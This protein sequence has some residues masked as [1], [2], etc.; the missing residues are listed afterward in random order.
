MFTLVAFEPGRE[1]T[2]ATSPSRW[3]GAYAL[4]YRVVAV[5]AR[6]SRLTV[7]L[8]MAYPPVLR[9]VLRRVG[10]AADFVMMRKQLLT[11]KRFAERDARETTASG[12]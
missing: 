7:K 3:L 4:T 12:S 1:I 2:L 5:G 6:R 11:L 10:S 8:V 9:S